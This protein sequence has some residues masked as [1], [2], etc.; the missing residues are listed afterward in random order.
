[1]CDSVKDS[2]ERRLQGFIAAGYGVNCGVNAVVDK[3]K[4]ILESAIEQQNDAIARLLIDASAH[5]L[6]QALP[7]AGAEDPCSL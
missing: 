6:E 5:A 1:L 4:T 2:D 3:C 7:A